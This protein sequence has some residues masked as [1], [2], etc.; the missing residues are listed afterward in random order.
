MA[1]PIPPVAVL[2]DNDG[3]LLDTESVWTRGQEALFQSRGIEFTLEHKQEQVGQSAENSG[4]IMERRLGEPGN[5]VELIGELN[6]LVLAELERGVQPMTGSL[7]LL[8]ALRESGMPLGLVSNSP[9]LFIDRAL[10]KAGLMNSFDVTLSA[11]DVAAPKPA[12]DPYIEACVLLGVKPADAIA[13]EDSPTGVASA[14][15]AGLTVIGVPS[16]PGIE[17]PEAHHVAQSLADPLVTE[18]L[19]LNQR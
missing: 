16:I 8:A 3:L 15:A 10:E 6:T 1:P 7:D 4:L 14:R 12:P 11:H 2:F 9:R 13:L 19:G 5:A 18:L 17:L